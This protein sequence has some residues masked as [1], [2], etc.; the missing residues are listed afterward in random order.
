[1][2][3]RST[4]S[5]CATSPAACSAQL[6]CSRKPSTVTATP[7]RASSRRSGSKFWPSAL[8]TT[9]PASCPRLAWMWSS[10]SGSTSE[11]SVSLGL[12]KTPKPT[13]RMASTQLRMASALP[14]VTLV[15]TPA[16]GSAP[17][18]WAC[19]TSQRPMTSKRGRCA[20]SGRWPRMDPRPMSI[21]GASHTSRYFI[22]FFSQRYSL[23]TWSASS[24]LP[25]NFV[26]TWRSVS[27]GHSGHGQPL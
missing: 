19:S 2:S 23:I 3:S 10:M 6:A 15:K 13:L 14:G 21:L 8:A 1:M 5:K 4:N 11:S 17:T 27:C 25:S 7:A 9:T 26:M 20:A 22:Y 16:S 24:P 12:A 18:A